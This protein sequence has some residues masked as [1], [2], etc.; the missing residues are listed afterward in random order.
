MPPCQPY[1]GSERD[2]DISA[3]AEP[4]ERGK[5]QKFAGQRGRHASCFFML[6][7]MKLRAPSILALAA[8]V[9]ILLSSGAARAQTINAAQQP[10]PDRILP[11]GANLG[12]S[13]RP[14]NLNPFGINYSDCVQNMVLQFSVTL[15][16]F[17][18]PNT[19]HMQVWASLSQDCTQDANRGVGMLPVCWLVNAGLP[20]PN[21]Q[22]HKHCNS[23]FL[24]GPSLSR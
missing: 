7:S 6:R 15:N 19:D 23:T 22:T 20:S 8:V 18:G 11:N 3:T 1:A 10:Y 21:I 17:P 13:T 5:E 16:G 4:S 12:Q 14:L 9:G 24:C 2:A